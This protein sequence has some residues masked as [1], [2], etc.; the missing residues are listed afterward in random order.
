MKHGK[1]TDTILLLFFLV[2]L[3]VLLRITIFRSDFGWHPLFEN[4]R[5]N[6]RLFYG[7]TSMLKRNRIRS[8]H[9]RGGR[10]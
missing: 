2:D 8:C 3:G 5:I 1:R 4:G 9:G 6:A 10:K 7:Y